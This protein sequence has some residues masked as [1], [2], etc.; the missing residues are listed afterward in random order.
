MIRGDNIRRWWRVHYR[1]E[2]AGVLRYMG[3]DDT[4]YWHETSVG[5]RAGLPRD[6]F[7]SFPYDPPYF[8]QQVDFWEGHV[9]KT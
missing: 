3:S 1:Y 9:E 6:C 2:G 4:P 7:F 5:G 8:R